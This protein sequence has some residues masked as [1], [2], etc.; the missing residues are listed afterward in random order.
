MKHRSSDVK[1]EGLFIKMAQ[2]FGKYSAGWP[3]H[4]E[5]CQYYL[6]KTKSLPKIKIQFIHK[7]GATCTESRNNPGS[8]LFV[9]FTSVSAILKWGMTGIFNNHQW[10]IFL[11]VDHVINLACF[12]T[13]L[14]CLVFVFSV[15]FWI[16]PSLQFLVSISM[17]AED[18]NCCFAAWES[19][20]Y[21]LLR[22]LG[23]DGFCV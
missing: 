8:I 10:F 6:T 15:C 23:V 12:R 1:A 22:C 16:S 7:G 3:I 13:V 5:V 17:S 21:R 14:K 19:N 11:N 9:S 2:A 18:F 20:A 4:R